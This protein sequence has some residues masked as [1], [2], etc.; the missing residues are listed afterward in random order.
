MSSGVTKIQGSCLHDH[1]QSMTPNSTLPSHPLILNQL[2]VCLGAEEAELWQVNYFF[3]LQKKVDFCS[4]KGRFF[5]LQKNGT[6]F[7]HHLFSSI[8][9]KQFY[10][11]LVNSIR[12]I[13]QQMFQ[14]LLCAGCGVCCYTNQQDERDVVSVLQECQ[15]TSG[16]FFGSIKWGTVVEVM[17]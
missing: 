3:P 5:P 14:S 7:S 8:C 10:Y 15:T 13:S 6:Q 9:D 16:M 4:G 2:C 17:G 1:L 11:P 12:I